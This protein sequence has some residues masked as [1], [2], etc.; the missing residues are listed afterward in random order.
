[1]V[2]A[3]RKCWKCQTTKPL[4][5]VYFYKDRRNPLGF[6]ACCKV[7][8]KER[9]K[10]YAKDHREY[11]KQKGREKYNPAENAG[12]YQKY[13]KDYLERR[14]EERTTAKVRLRELLG[15]ARKRATKSGLPFTITLDW[16]LEA[17][18]R[19]EGKCLL[20]G[21]LLT[22]DRNPYGMRF[23]RPYS[24]SLDQIEPGKGYTPENTRLV[25]VAVNLALNRF[26]E[27][28]FKLVCEGFLRRHQE[29]RLESTLVDLR[30][31]TVPEGVQ[32]VVV[33]VPPLV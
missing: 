16:A 1:M 24:P 17:F 13:R 3:E 28:V 22:F 32:P 15:V 31:V 5:P 2:S 6:Q 8:S 11:F 7:C 23:Y 9:G 19:Q 29:R 26:G 30:G 25:C 33:R 18:Q 20:T 21:I 10:Q 4:D 27:D 12:R 14:D